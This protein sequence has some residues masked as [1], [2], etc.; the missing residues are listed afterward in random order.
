MLV[1]PPAGVSA[2]PACRAGTSLAELEEGLKHKRFSGLLFHPWL[3]LRL[4]EQLEREGVDV[5]W[6]Y[7]V[8]AAVGSVEEDLDMARCSKETAYSELT[9]RDKL[10]DTAELVRGCGEHAQAFLES[11]FGFPMAEWKEHV[12][13]WEFYAKIGL[14]A[15]VTSQRV[16]L[17]R[18]TLKDYPHHRA[19][20]HFLSAAGNA[21]R[22]LVEE[23]EW[24]MVE[25]NVS[26]L[27][28]ARH[29]D[30]LCGVQALEA[31]VEKKDWDTAYRML[32]HL[33]HLLQD[34]GVPAHVR[35]DTH[36]PIPHPWNFLS[37]LIGTLGM[38]LR[39]D[40]SFDWF[41]PLE[42][43]LKQ[44]G[45]AFAL[46]DDLERQCGWTPEK[47][48]EPVGL[49]QAFESIRDFTA[50]HFYSRDTVWRGRVGEVVLDDVRLADVALHNLGSSGWCLQNRVGDP[51]ACVDQ[52]IL[53]GYELKVKGERIVFPGATTTGKLAR[54]G[55]LAVTDECVIRCLCRVVP[56]VREVTARYARQV[57]IPPAPGVSRGW[58]ENLK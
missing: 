17:F 32:G 16:A 4:F 52:E 36:A 14:L 26:A 25:R 49:D 5:P 7:R 1:A 28:W 40:R 34:M 58:K 57:P 2:Y 47:S 20:N 9:T 37:S 3:T 42:E 18:A 22:G 15:G 51:V 39:G 43:Y 35:N 48:G 46:Y 19:E 23:G 33:L 38:D 8:Q 55:K 24:V 41:D 45:D 12:K 11:W 21:K 13:E 44:N 30:N 27:E 56:V 50:M 6:R 53:E 31:A 10:L 54:T 29:P